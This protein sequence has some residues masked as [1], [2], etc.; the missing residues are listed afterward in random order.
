LII[1]YLADHPEFIPALAQ[2]TLDYYHDILP[3]ET[4]E[5]RCAKFRSHMHTDSLPL[6]L[7]ASAGGE[8]F[9]TGALREHDLPG[10]EELMP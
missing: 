4:L 9:G 8:L 5:T 2:E 1:D 7:V 3:E 10:H 6:A